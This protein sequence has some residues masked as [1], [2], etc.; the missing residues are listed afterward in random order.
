MSADIGFE[1]KLNRPYDDALEMTK[2]ALKAEGFG[3]L[4]SIDVKATMKEKLDVEFR[5]YTILG[6]CNPPL[7]HRALTQDA[8]AG[9]LL[10]C[11]VTVE[12]EGSSASIVRIANPQTIFSVGSLENNPEITAVAE[13]ARLRLER[14]AEALLA[15]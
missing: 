4:T 11:N 5:P 14:V 2:A 13:E 3:V 8:V 12:S 6:A 15:S 9:L 1:V 7:A 10:P